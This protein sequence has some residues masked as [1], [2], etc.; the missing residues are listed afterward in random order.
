MIDVDYLKKRIVRVFSHLKDGT[1]SGGTGFFISENGLLITCWHVLVN[2]DLRKL[3]QKDDFKNISASSE[4]ERIKIYFNNNI[5]KIEIESVDGIRE[6]VILKDF[7]YQYDFAIL[8]TMKSS[9]KKDFLELEVES[10]LN[11][12]DEAIFCGFPDS[13]DT[14]IYTTPFAINSGSVSAFPN[15]IVGGKKYIHLQLNG[16]NLGGN[17]GTALIR[18]DNNKVYGIINGNY[19]MSRDDFAVFN[20]IKNLSAGIKKI[21]FIVPLGITY[22][23]PLDILLNNSDIY[24]KLLFKL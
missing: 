1:T 6:K 17:S 11:Y 7:D 21:D 8:K 2:S 13:P 23:T 4:L 16:V 5:Q 14:T 9:G 3:K 24:Q 12:L 19:I 18:R 10:T 20:D 15:L 22:A